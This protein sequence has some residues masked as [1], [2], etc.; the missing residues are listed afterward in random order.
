MKTIGLHELEGR[1]T[2]IMRE[3]QE[4]GETVKVTDE[5]KAIALL[6]PVYQDNEQD[7]WTDLDPFV[8]EIS[9]YLPERVDAVEAVREIRG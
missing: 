8:D 3:V 9:R 5:G 4:S 6:M 7:S 2:E 1:I